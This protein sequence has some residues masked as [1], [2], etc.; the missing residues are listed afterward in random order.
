MST[1]LELLLYGQ[2]PLQLPAELPEGFDAQRL[3]PVVRPAADTVFHDAPE[4]LAERVQQAPHAFL[5]SGRADAEGLLSLHERGAELLEQIAGLTAAATSDEAGVPKALAIDVVDLFCLDAR[6]LEAAVERLRSHH[7]TVLLWIGARPSA[8]GTLD[9]ET[10]GLRKL[11]Q[12]E[13]HLPGVL[14]KHLDVVSHFLNKMAAYGCATGARVKPGDFASFGWVDVRLLA[15]EQLDSYPD[16]P[17]ECAPRFMRELAQPLP[18]VLVV[19]EPKADDDDTLQLG[20]GRAAR[21]VEVMVG[22]AKQCG[23]DSGVDIPRC[24]Q[25][26]VLCTRIAEGPPIE[27]RR[28]TQDEPDASGWVAI[29]CERGHDHQDPASFVVQPLQRLAQ[30][31]PRLFPMLAAPPGTGLLITG[32][33]EMTVLLPEEGLPA[34]DDAG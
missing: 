31:A 19:A 32:D 2:A 7:P 24:L 25:T 12:R 23:F 5:L 3:T 11:D 16:D 13:V 15:A 26:A 18:G 4:G 27:A 34:D 30:T 29:C 6:P 9:V 1:R 8:E 33:N 10:F 17:S 20:A 22:A 28:T 14:P 21:V